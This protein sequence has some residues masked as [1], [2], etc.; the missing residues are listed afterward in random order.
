MSEL[1]ARLGVYAAIDDV[2]A[3]S[4][5]GLRAA[6]D[7]IPIYRLDVDR[8]PGADERPRTV[9]WSGDLRELVG[10]GVGGAVA[11][12]PIPPLDD[13]L[14]ELAD[15]EVGSDLDRA[16]RLR[17]LWS[18][19][20]V[21]PGFAEDARELL[22]A[23]LA[24]VGTDDGVASTLLELLLDSRYRTAEQWPELVTAA[25]E[26]H[27]ITS[28]VATMARIGC[29][30]WLTPRPGAGG[31][32]SPYAA[33]I[34]SSVS[35]FD[36]GTRALEEVWEALQPTKWPT[37]L[38]SF[39]CR[40][41]LIG[42]TLASATIGYFQEQVGDCPTIWFQPYLRFAGRDLHDSTGVVHGFELQYDMATAT[43]LAALGVQLSTTFTQDDR[44]EVD[45]GKIKVTLRQKPG[46]A[47]G[48]HE[49]D[50]AISKSIRLEGV[51]SGGVALLACLSGWADMT[52][53]MMDGCL[54]PTHA[55]GGSSDG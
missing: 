27:L 5:D 46:S 8:G 23:A 34:V 28:T 55:P 47:P 33:R 14:R 36:V 18:L 11:A 52:R 1:S 15:T 3:E 39:W 31:A 49:V 22:T 24:P 43:D 44:V 29:E 45:S 16:R 38:S 30:D 19:T 13:A 41:D 12:P 51:S 37:C 40:L 6:A 42:P 54:T 2:A 20:H 4:V 53:M 25:E 26:E 35:G 10:A 9:G 50:I 7:V 17:A 48:H 32:V 21:V